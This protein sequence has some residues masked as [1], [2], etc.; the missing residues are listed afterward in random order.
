MRTAHIMAG[1]PHGGAELFFERLVM[2]Q[3][4][5]GDA[6]LPTIRTDAARA[7]RL[8]PANPLQLPFGG[9]FDLQTRPRLRAAL[10]GFA[11]RVAVAWMNRAARFAPPGDWVLAGRLGGYYDLKYYQSCD[12]LIG[13]TRT[14]TRWITA[15]GWPAARTH[16]L[17]N[18]APDLHAAP[19]ERLGIAPGQRIVL[20]LGRLHRNKAFDVL[21]RALPRL[22]GVHAV[23]AGEGPERDALQTLARGEGVADRVL[24]PG[25]RDDTAALL[26]GCD[27]LACPS[28]HEPLGNVVVEAW[29]AARPVVAA[30][31]DGPRELIRPGEDG[32]LV[33]PED[34]EAL[35]TSLRLVLDNGS[36]AARL[37]EA[38]RV[39]YLAEFAEAPVLAQWRGFLATV[40]KPACAA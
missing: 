5:A 34:V 40:E 7:L 31:A 36:F 26:A 4:G 8:A 39:R 9:A 15:Q 37:A 30:A 3:H 16:Y 24:F 38:G 22:P 2:A 10:R 27:A 19:P 35:A 1:A 28:R 21:I 12:H 17:P 6:V 14:L 25:W 20:A 18:F 23:I 13:N 32:L 29:S 11:P 33:P